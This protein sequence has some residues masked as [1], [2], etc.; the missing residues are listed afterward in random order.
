MNTEATF[1]Q[2]SS[3]MGDH[4]GNHSAADVDSDIDSA[5]SQLDSVF[6]TPI[7]RTYASL[8]LDGVARNYFLST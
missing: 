8:P 3:W 5:R 2:G 4:K 7:P 6:F 1:A